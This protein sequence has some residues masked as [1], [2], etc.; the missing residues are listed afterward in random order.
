[1]IPT[2]STAGPSGI[3]LPTSKRQHIASEDESNESD[4]NTSDS[5]DQSDTTNEVVIES[6]QK[7]KKKYKQNFRKQ[8]LQEFDWIEERENEPFCRACNIKLNCNYNHL[9]RHHNSKRHLS[10]LKIYLNSKMKINKYVNAEQISLHKKAKSGELKMLMFLHEH[11]LPFVLM[12][13]LP[14]LIRSVCPDSHIAKEIKCGRTKATEIS[15]NQLASEASE[16]LLKNLATSKYFSL[17][18]DES[19]DVSTEK[20]VIVLIRFFFD[21]KTCDR[22]F[23]FVTYLK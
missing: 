14:H 7:K 16:S 20:C 10:K 3:C 15:K 1:M 19:T 12:D 11:R 5:S 23:M 9:K 8:W 22:Y 2:E 13:H 17:L 6:K 18:I 4:L 21:G